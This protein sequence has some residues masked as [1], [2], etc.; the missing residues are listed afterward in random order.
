M[1]ELAIRASW[2]CDLD[3]LSAL[4]SVGPSDASSEDSHAAK[5]ATPIAAPIERA[6]ITTLR[7]ETDVVQSDGHR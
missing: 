6:R 2:R 5:T 1:R 7:D 3:E 4:A